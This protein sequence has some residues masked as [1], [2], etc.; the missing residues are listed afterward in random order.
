[1]VSGPLLS[2]WL[3]RGLEAG[4]LSGLVAIAVLSGLDLV[5]T[6]GPVALPGPP[7]GLFVLAPAVLPLA[8]IP[9]SYPTAMA[10]T[11]TDALLGALTA[12][13][14]AADA[15]ALVVATRLLL[16]GGQLE[17]PAGALTAGLALPAVVV[18]ILAGQLAGPVGFGRRAG[19]RSAL[20]TLV[21]SIVVLA[22]AAPFA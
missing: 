7:A 13:L 22:L 11:R 19:A 16:A 18:G 15:T 20:A 12:F 9:V 17:V 14:V 4:V 10:A 21:A 3:R 6:S 8:V 2:P 5:A 1:M